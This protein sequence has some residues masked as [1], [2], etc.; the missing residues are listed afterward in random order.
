MDNKR[1]L[2]SYGDRFVCGRSHNS[3]RTRMYSHAKER[4]TDLSQ[5]FANKH[6]QTDTIFFALTDVHRKTID[7]TLSQFCTSL[8]I[9]R[10]SYKVQSSSTPVKIFQK[11]THGNNETWVPVIR[12]LDGGLLLLLCCAH[13]IAA[14]GRRLHTRTWTNKRP[15]CSKRIRINIQ[16]IYTS[17]MRV[18]PPVLFT[19]PMAACTDGD[20]SSTNK[21]FMFRSWTNEHFN[22]RIMDEMNTQSVQIAPV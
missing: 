1:C 21:L 13:T 11:D 17:P 19:M 18:Q 7:P 4:C 2:R 8:T 3:A 15:E 6:T 9:T 12:S 22:V 10:R 5:L 14:I 20:R 16:D